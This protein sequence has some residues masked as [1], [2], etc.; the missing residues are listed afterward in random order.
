MTVAGQLTTGQTAWDMDICGNDAKPQ[1]GSV[2][3]VQE[4]TAPRITSALR[5]Q[6]PKRHAPI[7]QPNAETVMA[8][9]EQTSGTASTD[10]LCM[11]NPIL[12]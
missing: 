8:L 5:A 4:N 7:T 1:R 6:L 12:V 10:R 11:R 9:I 3:S 2:R